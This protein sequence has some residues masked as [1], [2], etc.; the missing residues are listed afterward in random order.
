MK[1]IRKLLSVFYSIDCSN[2]N[3]KTGDNCT[4]WMENITNNWSRW[5]GLYIQ[6]SNGSHW[7]E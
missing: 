1:Q 7:S 5:S 2:K 3:V 6:R 4:E